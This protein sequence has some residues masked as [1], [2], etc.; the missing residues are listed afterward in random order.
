MS[1]TATAEQKTN[2][3]ITIEDAGPSRKKLTIEIPAETVDEH[4]GNSLET[5]AVEAQLPGFRK[6]H[7]PKRLLEKK[8]GGT[9]RDEAKK[10]LIATAYSEAVEQH[11]L[12]VIG[13]PSAEKLSEVQVEQGKPVVF[14]VDVEVAPEF[15]LPKLEGIAVKKPVVEVTDEMV[16]SEL[17]RIRIN[18]GSLE[19]R[20]EPEAGD[21]LT[22]HGVMKGEVEGKEETFYDIPGAVVRVPPA[23]AEGKGMIL[24]V[25]VED[26]AK[27]LG[28]PKPGE[29]ATIKVKGPE[30]HENERLRGVDLTV[31]FK[32]DRVDRIVPASNDDVVSKYGMESVDQLKNIVRQRLEQRTMVQ[33]QT[34]MR[35]QI[36]RHL[37]D[38]VEMELPERLTSG[39]AERTLHR[40]RLELLY[41]GVD[42]QRIEEHMAE[43][44]ASS[45]QQ[46]AR[47]LKLFFILDK[48]AEQ[49]GVRVEEHEINA[50]IYQIAMERGERPEALRQQLIANRQVGTIF[51]Q[52]REHKAMDALIAKAEIQEMPAEQFNEEMKKLQAGE[53]TAA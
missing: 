39:Q 23:D 8:F 30:N 20:Q 42:E 13:E 53:D 38:N 29:T 32:V 34:V 5:L 11:K 7:A 18:E 12:R 4:L 45:S 27:Q 21:Y 36:A 17:E 1:D 19:E 37:L 35:Q 10:Q 43:M 25:L 50:R 15:E 33:Q 9:I 16:E 26:F 46:A 6:G 47:E 41:R 48:V 3:K 31:T 22:G 44:R 51:Q 2:S 14:T 49:E 28:L 52:I 24:G 40:R